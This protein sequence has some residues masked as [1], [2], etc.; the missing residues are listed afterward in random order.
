MDDEFTTNIK[1]FVEVIEKCIEMKWITVNEYISQEGLASQFANKLREI[2]Y[3][4]KARG[5][6]G[7]LIW[8]KRWSPEEFK[9]IKEMFIENKV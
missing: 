4:K 7:D 8:L 2:E 9:A 1:A 6:I 3:N 5:M